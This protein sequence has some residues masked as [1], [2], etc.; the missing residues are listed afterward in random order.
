MKLVTRFLILGILLLSKFTSAQVSF[1]GKKHTFYLGVST[2]LIGIK[3]DYSIEG[4]TKVSFDNHYLPPTISLSY[5]KVTRSRMN[6][7]FFSSY[8]ALDNTEIQRN[9]SIT[10]EF[11]TKKYTDNV[12]IRSNGLDIGINI[13]LFTDYAPIGNFFSIKLGFRNV[14]GRIFPSYL[15]EY[16]DSEFQIEMREFLIENSSFFSS[17]Y[18]FYGLGIGKSFFLS[19]KCTLKYG[20]Q[21][22]L[23]LSL[24]SSKNYQAIS[25]SG[26]NFDSTITSTLQLNLNRSFLLEF[27]VKIGFIK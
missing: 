5:G 20:I 14:F 11:V 25:L 3:T 12:K 21:S 2:P 18:L 4:G 10:E 1:L 22:S 19:K 9:S 17:K 27:Y 7:I 8:S 26:E 24:S 6:L 16:N 23:S 15:Y 13:D